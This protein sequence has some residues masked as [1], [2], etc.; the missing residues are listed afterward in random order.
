MKTIAPIETRWNG[1]KFR[2]RTEARWV[3]YLTIA[4]VNW[5][6]EKEGYHLPSGNYLPDFWLIN[7]GLRSTM[8]IGCW[9]EIKGHSP[10]FKEIDLAKE[11]GQKTEN[12]SVIFVG[13]PNANELPH[14]IQVY[15]WDDNFMQFVK[16]MG[17][18]R[19]K[20]EYPESNYS[21]YE[22]CGGQTNFE[23]PKLV[24]AVFASRSARFEFGESGPT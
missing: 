14:S 2:S 13:N 22:F 8:K 16:C 1:Y 21:S 15:P 7:V 18:G 20:I 4:G 5:E 24:E 10:S 23:H 12:P 19:I 11:L 9:L 17:C 3:V 6:Y